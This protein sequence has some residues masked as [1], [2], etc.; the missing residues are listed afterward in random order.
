[1]PFSWQPKPAWLNTVA[2]GGF[3]IPVEFQTSVAAQGQ[4]L[5]QFFDQ[6]EREGVDAVNKIAAAAKQPIKQTVEFNVEDGKLQASLKESYAWTDKI[7]KAK[8]TAEKNEQTRRAKAEAAAKK[9]AAAAERV[10]KAE[11]R[12]RIARG[13]A[14][15]E[16]TKF[17]QRQIRELDKIRQETFKATEAQNKLGNAGKRSGIA[18][19]SGFIK[20]QIAMA[21]LRIA[22]E[23]FGR[24]LD[25]AFNAE[26]ASKRLENITG[27][28]A[29]YEQA[30]RL[31]K[32]ASAD[33]GVTQTEATQSIGD[34]YS[35]LS[36]VGYGLT[37]VNEIY[38]GFNT[39]ARESG[40]AAEEASG[41]FFQLSQG[42]GSGKLAG[43]E[44]RS[45]LE[46]MPQLTAR[47]AEEM[48]VSAGQIKELGAAGKITGDVIYKALS[49]AATGAVNLDDKLTKQQLTMNQ[50]R[51]K[52]EEM[53][54]A[55]GKA[56][57]PI[58]LAFLEKF[59][60]FATV[61]AVAFQ[62]L[63]EWVSKNAEGIKTMLKAG[64]EIAKM[65]GSVW[66]VIKAY[67]AW[68][69]VTKALAA[70][71]AA[72][73]AL[74][75]VGMGKILVAVGAAATVY[76][77]LTVA[78]NE[79]S[80]EVERL[81]EESGKDMEKLRADAEKAKT[82]MS[83]IPEPLADVETAMKSVTAQSKEMSQA[84]TQAADDQLRLAEATLQAE[85]QI[86]EVKLEQLNRA[87]DSA[88]TQEQRIAIAKQIYDLTLIQAKLERQQ[89]QAAIDAG[90]RKT[91]LAVE[92]L[93]IKRE[94]IEAEKFAAMARNQS[95]K[96]FEKALESIS[97]ALGLAKNMAKTSAAI[98]EQQERAADAIY[99]GAEAA[100]RA[101]FEQNTVAQASEQAAISSNKYA[102]NMERGAKAAEKAAKKTNA[103]SGG[104]VTSNGSSISGT[105]E[106][107]IA[108]KSKLGGFYSWEE[109]MAALSKENE[110]IEKREMAK[111][112]Q[113]RKDAA[114]QEAKERSDTNI[115]NMQEAYRVK[116]EQSAI[117]AERAAQLGLQVT[118]QMRANTVLLNKA[119]ARIASA[120]A[121]TAPPARA[122]GGPVAGGSTYQVNELGR[123][124]FLSASGRMSEIKV[125]A[126]GS[127]KAPST[128]EV[129]PAHVWAEMKAASAMGG[130]SA[131]AGLAGA[132]RRPSA[133]PSNIDN[134]R[135]TNHVT[136]QSQAP[137][138]TA[139]ELMVASAK[140][141]RRR[142]R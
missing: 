63:N 51:Q 56:F 16:A 109:F 23:Q 26:K 103:I 57:A 126:Y 87:L 64:L 14:A 12:Q 127:W 138:Q 99:D 29:E 130:N 136:I 112:E 15:R 11:A 5:Q 24:T 113:A 4:S 68:V 1:M 82:E 10:T 91:Q 78:T 13:V 53:Q 100:A 3:Q 110:R 105:E 6:V 128:G 129:I 98:A 95:T 76:G 58:Y 60:E 124:G 38:R 107:V 43:D 69:A 73:L 83:K 111:R 125:P 8:A 86:N 141:R 46:R 31:A 134:S 9:E 102:D 22:T 89:A 18:I 40:V 135:I 36:S 35:R 75:G 20:A 77:A 65:S 45:I 92:E 104:G 132:S 54:I 137:V 2:N 79:A 118:D 37:E 81:G 84:A 7:E 114:Y 123:E 88:K 72:F 122:S 34:L 142:F 44:L 117:T 121:F 115:L 17:R 32:I 120:N 62:K 39:I 101:A 80:K 93:K 33:F 70:A 27:S 59:A 21:T 30:L 52:T 48:N 139:S 47:L 90:V 55:I 85:M 42:L 140:R 94:L 66:I 119:L 49:K 41:A 25:V 96:G 74:T 61:T 131:P 19:V 50:V 106:A 133:G 97:K 67:R 28:V 71:K 116:F 108:A